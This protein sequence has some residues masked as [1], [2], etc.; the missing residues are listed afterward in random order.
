MTGEKG[1]AELPVL[2][3]APEA[4]LKPLTAP[5]TFSIVIPTYEAAETVAASIESAL[6]QSHRAHEV[7]VVDDGSRDDLDQVLSPFRE[8]IELVRKENGGGA[9]ALNAG[10]EAASG[11]FL[12]IL[13]ADDAYDPR[14]LEALAGLARARPDL[15]LITTDARFVVAGKEAGR[16]VSSA[17]GRRSGESA[18]GPL[19]ASTRAYEPGTTGT[20]GS[21]C[22]SA[23]SR[24]ASS[25]SPITS[26]ASIQAA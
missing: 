17:V 21:A 12:A 26:I 13:D 15:D 11:E 6:G 25:R 1:Q 4:E 24:S 19:G 2:A 9:S 5:P 16:A 3:P 8:R 7:I 20:V 10:A 18:C 22:F 23:G 14:R